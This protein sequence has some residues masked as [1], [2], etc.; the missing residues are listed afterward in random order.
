MEVTMKSILGR[1]VIVGTLTTACLVQIDRGGSSGI[2]RA[3]DS[4]S[5]GHR[6]G[7]FH[8]RY[9]FDATGTVIGVGDFAA[10][11][12]MIFNANGTLT[13]TE[14]VNL[15]GQIFHINYTGSYTLNPDNT[16]TITS[17]DENG[18]VSTFD[19]VLT[20]GRQR[21]SAVQRDEGIITLVK[22]ERQ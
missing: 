12:V 3:D 15:D 8:G 20:A 7:R 2:A 13:A 6:S 17:I 9:G 22:L 14:S 16:G 21:A 5:E 10:N 1:L 4:S 11:G 19:W 18:G